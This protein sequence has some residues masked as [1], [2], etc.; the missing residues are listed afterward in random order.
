MDTAE[1]VCTLRGCARAFTTQRGLSQHARR[2]HP[3]EY[4]EK[5]QAADAAKSRRTWSSEEIYLLAKTEADLVVAGVSLSAREW[6]ERLS[7]SS[8]RSVEAI[9]GRRKTTNYTALVRNLCEESRHSMSRE[10]S[11]EVNETETGAEESPDPEAEVDAETSGEVRK[12]VLPIALDP[13]LPPQASP[14]SEQGEISTRSGGSNPTEQARPPLEEAGESDLGEIAEGDWC[15]KL[16]D[17]LLSERRNVKEL[18]S[19]VDA[20]QEMLDRA[21]KEFISEKLPE[22]TGKAEPKDGRIK[23]SKGKKTGTKCHVNGK[24]QRRPPN[25]KARRAHA[26]G[27]TQS[28]YEKE[29]AV[30]I[31][32][33]LKGEEIGS[34]PPPFPAGTLSFWENLVGRVPQREM[35]SVRPVNA[36]Q[37][38]VCEIISLGEVK[39][40]LK[41]LKNSAPGLDS[42]KRSDIRSVDPRELTDWMNL[43]L[44]LRK[45][46][47]PF[48]KGRTTLIPKVERPTDPSEYRPI[49]VTS[50][51]SRLF[52]SILAK[53]LRNVPIDVRQKGYRNFD[54]VGASV[55]K[56]KLIL[57]RAKSKLSPLH[58][59]FLDVKKAFD[60]VSP[61]SMLLAAERVGVPP[62][63][64]D[65][66][67]HAHEGC[68]TQF[69]CDPE[70]REV[71]IRNGVKQGDP[72]SCHLFNFTM[73]MCLETLKPAIGFP[74]TAEHRVNSG[75]LADD[76]WL[77][78]STPEGLK[79]LIDTFVEEL[80]K[81]GMEV[82]ARKC[83]VLHI[84]VDRKK[85]KWYVGSDPVKID[86][87]VCPVMGP[88][89]VYKYLGVQVSGDLGTS[90]ENLPA[91]LALWLER[92]SKSHLKPQQ[93]LHALRTFVI[94]AMY[95]V[96]SLGDCT[97]SFLQALDR[98]I[99]A[100]VRR[101][102]H[103]PKDT[104]NAYIWSDAQK[105]GLGVPC[106]RGK[107][108]VLKKARWEALRG[109]ERDPIME[110]LL[111]SDL[112]KK[113]S[114]RTAKPI[115]LDGCSVEVSKT[116]IDTH[117]VDRLHA[118]VDGRGLVHFAESRVRQ[119]KWV[120]DGDSKLSGK[121]YVQAVK[122]RGSL[123]AT[124]SRASRGRALKSGLTQVRGDRQAMCPACPDKVANLA[125]MSQTCGRTHG[126][127]SQ[128]HNALVKMLKSALERKGYTCYAEPRIPKGGTYLKPDL[129]CFRKLPDAREVDVLLV[130]PTIVSDSCDFSDPLNVKFDKYAV[131]EVNDWCKETARR[132]SE[133]NELTPVSIDIRGVALDWRGCWAQESYQF[134]TQGVKLSK[135][136][137]ELMSVRCL[138]SLAAC[139]SAQGKR[140]DM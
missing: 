59:A 99:L 55:W 18:A 52:H 121:E 76:S 62:P 75:L 81:A 36:V 93:R 27:V 140:T 1:F 56:L 73:D 98:Q 78:A 83:A 4:H 15:K 108:A 38:K 34:K 13:P 126:W 3:A 104:S 102:L 100:S 35:R 17:H 43:W 92:L 139:F 69:S 49:T 29:S 109:C 112:G 32:R 64:L 135:R 103:L 87:A 54:G 90:E 48:K 58:V 74:V 19:L 11:A 105:G 86:G 63:L 67:R 110:A 111:G 116:S 129:V 46:P 9:R 88:G 119:S 5:A 125:H 39:R 6:A 85:K 12:L 10:I 26:R 114:Y 115:K 50:F 14:A 77:A 130:D 47:L 71:P 132:L 96:L 21:W 84:K 31:R 131:G 37:W 22:V 61:G 28:L 30:L 53:R 79:T 95:H 120:T 24:G 80:R 42:A 128:R 16:R 51:F 107:T 8:T 89:Q 45:A 117:L 65:Y 137:L 118:T 134:L 70:R 136:Y 122:V 82:N 57:Q 123:L 72:L 2:T 33:I 40:A 133:L 124:R 66:L 23:K 101:W 94:P 127:R 60:S 7:K 41:L 44:Y 25:R 68:T 113:V 106:V 20:D 91:K 138:T 97:R